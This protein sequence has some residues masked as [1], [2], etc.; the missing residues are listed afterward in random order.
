MKSTKIFIYLIGSILMMNSV[1]AGTHT[2]FIA[3]G[4]SGVILKS[5]DDG[6]NWV[7]TSTSN[8]TD[9]LY[10]MNFSES[11]YFAVGDNGTLVTSSD[12][13]SWNYL[14]HG[15]GTNQKILSITSNNGYMIAVGEKGLLL[16]SVNGIKW[17][18][19]DSHTL[20]DIQSI[21]YAN[22]IGFVAVGDNGTIISSSDGNKWG[23]QNIS[24]NDLKS[25][26]YNGRV[27]VVVGNNGAILTSNDGSNWVN[28][29]SP[30]SEDLN[31]IIYGN[32]QFLAVGS[33]GIIL[34]S[35]DFKAARSW[36]KNQFNN[37]SLLTSI[38]YGNGKFI[39]V[40]E[41]GLIANS[42]DGINWNIV[43]SNTR[44]KFTNVNSNVFSNMYVLTCPS[45]DE[46]SSKKNPNNRF[47][48][49][50]YINADGIVYDTIS[51]Y[52]ASESGVFL[53]FAGS[54]IYTSSNLEQ[55]CEYSSNNTISQLTSEIFDQN[56]YNCNPA[57]CRS[58]ISH[59]PIPYTTCQVTCI[60]K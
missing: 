58:V 57:H 2:Q 48:S 15:L 7:S 16:S 24:N 45:P 35:S 28:Q 6:I 8:S 25:V 20:Y 1:I 3:I 17:T 52:L 21:T 31:S 59:K 19:H 27:F 50:T 30:T 44:A 43:D 4:E 18:F 55:T 5:V 51:S 54:A 42:Q 38:T 11:K 34:S 9:N 39:V 46:I 60:A 41:N 12:G 26:I 10:G 36:V 53:D 14:E 32:G 23:I 56:K 47:F 22:G 37:T 29:I 13:S 40:G 33:N 49:W